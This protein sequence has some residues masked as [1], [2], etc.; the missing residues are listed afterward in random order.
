MQRSRALENPWDGGRHNK[1]L[2]P[3]PY[4]G[5]GGSLGVLPAPPACPPVPGS[6]KVPSWHGDTS[7]DAGGTPR[8]PPWWGYD[9]EPPTRLWGSS[10]GS[11]PGDPGAASMPASPAPCQD[12]CPCSASSFAAKSSGRGESLR[13]GAVQGHPGRVLGPP[14]PVAASR[15][16]SREEWRGQ[17]H[18]CPLPK[19]SPVWFG[20][21]WCEWGPD[22]APS[23][24]RIAPARR[25]PG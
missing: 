18:L 8:S 19:L 16:C 17:S 14:A 2:V 4:L 12:P 21:N 25:T 20:G 6:S 5:S 15:G 7:R 1:P 10:R 24:P 22:L 23:S 9:P 11:H 13:A 3:A